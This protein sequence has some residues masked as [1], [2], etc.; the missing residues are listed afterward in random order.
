[1]KIKEIYIP[2][3]VLNSIHN[4]NIHVGVALGHE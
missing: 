4:S 2:I 3:P 1:M